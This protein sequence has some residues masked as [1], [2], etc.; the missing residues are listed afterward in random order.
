MREE[1]YQ[2]SLWKCFDDSS[3][4]YK[5]RLFAAS[6]DKEIFSWAV[7][8]TLRVVSIAEAESTYQKD[9]RGLPVEPR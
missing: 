4:R 5:I 1:S 2:A 9:C 3:P 7:N 6:A 8:A